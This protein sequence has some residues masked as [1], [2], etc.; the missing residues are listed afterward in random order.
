MPMV[1]VPSASVRI[2]SWL[3]VYF[4]SEGTFIGDSPVTSLNEALAVAHEGQLDHASN[5][6]LVA[7]EHAHLV[8]R[9]DT[10][11]QP[12][13]RYGCGQSRRKRAAGDLAIAQ[14]RMDMLV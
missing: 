8:A 13:Q 6:F 4:R 7:N 10:N 9:R 3:A 1:S 14:R 12:R 5:E 2:H 11:R